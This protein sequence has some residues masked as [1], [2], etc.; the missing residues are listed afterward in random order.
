MRIYPNTNVDLTYQNGG[1]V[2]LVILRGAK[3]DI[4]QVFNGL[5][6]LGATGGELDWED[7]KDDNGNDIAVFWSN[8][9]NMYKFFFNL[10]FF[11][12]ADNY[13]GIKYGVFPACYEFADSQIELLQSNPVQFRNFNKTKSVLEPYSIGTNIAEKPDEDFKDAVLKQAFD[14]KRNLV[15]KLD[16]DDQL[17]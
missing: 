5:W 13:K 2:W 12:N 10:F 9:K 17:V 4:E 8:H 14:D 6:N 7:F 16:L 15:K 1:T 3:Q 11:R